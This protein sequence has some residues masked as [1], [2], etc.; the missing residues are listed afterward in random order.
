MIKVSAF[1]VDNKSQY[2]QIPRTL[3]V[4]HLV[5]F[6]DRLSSMKNMI[7]SSNH[8]INTQEGNSYTVTRRELLLSRNSRLKL[9]TRIL[10]Y[11]TVLKGNMEGSIA[12]LSII[13][14]N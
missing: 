8:T 6:I 11:K 10:C 13:A 5:E 14:Q 7:T 3:T 1:N 2:Y 12:Y 9:L 4:F